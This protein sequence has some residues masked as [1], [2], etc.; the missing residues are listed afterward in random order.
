MGTYVMPTRMTVTSSKTERYGKATR[1]V[2]IFP[3]LRPYL[4]EAC[5]AKD[6]DKSWVV[7]M[8][9]GVADRHDQTVTD[10]H[11][12]DAQE[13]GDELGMQH[14]VLNRG[15]AHEK[16]RSVHNVRENVSFSEVVAI[17]EDSLPCG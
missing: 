2:P 1:W 10:D 17:L 15:E 14:P 6:A 7:P 9:A 8:M 13:S 16:T 11:F 3:E 4:D 12:A 5:F